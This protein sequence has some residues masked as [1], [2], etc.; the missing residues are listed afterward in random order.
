MNEKER[1]GERYQYSIFP[2]KLCPEDLILPMRPWPLQVLI[3]SHKFKNKNALETDILELLYT[4]TVQ[5]DS[6][7]NPSLP[8]CWPKFY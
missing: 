3:P 7:V 8:I 5:D 2:S 6:Q 1:E 4:F